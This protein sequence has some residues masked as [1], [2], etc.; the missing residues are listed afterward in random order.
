MSKFLELPDCI[1]SSEAVK[2]IQPSSPTPN[3]SLYLS[4]LDD[5]KFLR[6][7]IKY[8][9]IFKKSVCLDLLK[10]SLSRV[11]VDYYPLAGRLRSSSSSSSSM[12]DHKLEVNCNGEGAVFA[13]AFMDIT[14][15][16]LLESSK[17]PNKS[18]R[19][20]LYKVEAQSFLDVPPLV[21]QVRFIS[22][23]DYSSHTLSFD[24]VNLFINFFS[25][26]HS[27]FFFS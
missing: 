22:S 20:F 5:Q 15:Q 9:Y 24:K 1:Y 12:D 11:L 27:F 25:A 7:S 23:A 2:I 19:K 26:S 17:L 10:C 4:N 3:H 18:W 6:F 21:V 13:E 16:Q 14:A 8:L